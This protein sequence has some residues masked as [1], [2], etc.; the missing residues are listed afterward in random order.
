MTSIDLKITTLVD[1][2]NDNLS[3]LINDVSGPRKVNLRTIEWRLRPKK[4]RIQA[5]KVT[6][7]NLQIKGFRPQNDVF[8]PSK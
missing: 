5:R 8:L 4:S 6:F 3:R 2:Q 7:L 1:S